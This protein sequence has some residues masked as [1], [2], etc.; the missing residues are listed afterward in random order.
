MTIETKQK[1][2]KGFFDATCKCGK[3][4]GWYGFIYNRPTCPKCGDKQ[5]TRELAV[6]EK[7]FYQELDAFCLVQTLYHEKFEL[8]TTTEASFIVNM[9]RRGQRKQTYSEIQKVSIRRL[10]TK[11]NV[12]PQHV[13]AEAENTT[14]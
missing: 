13:D 9:Y 1:S 4:I 8:M 12:R 7:S 14:K 10:A 11:Y 3:R 2:I 5:I 6:V